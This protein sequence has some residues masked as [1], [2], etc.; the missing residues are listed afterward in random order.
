MGVELS[1]LNRANCADTYSSAATI[2]ATGTKRITIFVYNNAVLYQL[3]QDNAGSQW[4]V[5]ESE[6]PPGFHSFARECSGIRFRNL[7][8]GSI[9]IVSAKMLQ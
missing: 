8:P 4:G 2:I 3:A 7:Q 6:L 9:A 1:A 5:A